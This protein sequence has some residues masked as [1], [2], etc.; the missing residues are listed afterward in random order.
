MSKPLRLLLIVLPLALIVL[1]L[2]QKSAR[3]N[4]HM[5]DTD[6]EY[7]YV[8]SGMNICN[9]STPTHVQG[10]GTPLQ[11]LSAVVIKVVHI[12]RSTKDTL[13]VDVMKNPDIYCSAINTFLIFLIAVSIFLA[14]IAV[15]FATGN[16]FAGVF[17][18]LIPFTKWI[19]LDL[20][21]RIM[22]ESLIISGVILLMAFVVLYIYDQK[23]DPKKWINKYVIVFGILIGFIAS[24]KLVYLPIAILPF[25]II[26]GPKQKAAYTL[27]S[28]LA[29]SIFSFSIFFHWV[30]FRDW[31]IINFFHSGMYGSG[32]ATIVDWGIFRN[33]FK[34][35]FTNNNFYLITLLTSSIVLLFY[36]I[37]FV[38]LK[39][40]ND[41][42][43]YAFLGIYI[44]MM[45]LT[46]LI[47]KQYKEYYLAVNYLLII[48]CWFFIIRIASRIIPTV[49]F[50]YIQV[51]ALIV[52]LFVVWNNGPKLVI[53][54]HSIRVDK[55]EMYTESLH[56]VEQNIYSETPVLVLANYYGAPFKEYGLYFAM[57][58]S[59]HKMA[60]KYAQDLNV[61][62]P[63]IYFYHG[64]NNSFNQWGTSHSYIDLVKKYQK[65]V[66]YSGDKAWEESLKH[67]LKGINRQ[68]DTKWTMIKNFEKIGQ[69][70]YEVK[71][72]SLAA[73]ISTYICDAEQIDS[74]SRYFTNEIGQQF[75]GAAYLS[76]DFS[77]SGSQSVKLLKDQDGFTCSLSEVQK[78]D[79]YLIEVWCK[80]GHEGSELL[81]Q[82]NND[83]EFLLKTSAAS[84]SEKGWEKLSLTFTVTDQLHNHDLKIFCRN[85]DEENPAFFDDLVINRVLLK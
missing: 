78:G 28:I 17:F 70:F 27:A 31:Y 52:M 58:W 84:I 77:R 10:P 53:D 80:S 4:Y 48:P 59:G 54:Y 7:A 9:L 25:L 41:K 13:N 29:F 71:Y 18:Q 32:Q 63:H 81:V 49:S 62:Y 30:T 51:A 36:L 11:V 61:L 57:G 50:K 21:S 33:N 14:G 75:E 42:E 40:K 66:F 12:F 65:V 37:P 56:Y 44:A 43:F 6:P 20:N 24:N 79:Q 76:T 69:T 73:N 26:K 8:F 83:Q 15:S 68:I 3:T 38:K 39:R 16:I 72:D 34:G 64:W 85:L 45:V 1:S 23:V 5:Y 46:I 60:M 74:L 67:K 47:S 2:H 22:V 35:I 55:D 82:S 19:L